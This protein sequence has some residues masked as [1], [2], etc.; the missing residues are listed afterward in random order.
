MSTIRVVWGSGRAPT[1]MASFDAALKAANIHNYNLV[2][3]SSVIPD[4]V[5]VEAVGTA[6]DLGPVGNRLTVVE[7]MAT[8]SPGADESAAAAL[9]WAQTFS[10]KGIFYEA[11]GTDPEDV[12]ARVEA[13][14]E[15]GKALRDWDFGESHV[16]VETAEADPEE[17]VTALVV[18][19]YGQSDPLV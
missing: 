5:T 1:P 17:Y 7:G 3:V 2:T 19:A 8:V 18:A 15:A 16:R 4:D 14:L 13:G 10:G 9:A 11:S 6:P 12:R